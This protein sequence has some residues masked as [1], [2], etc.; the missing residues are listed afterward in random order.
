MTCTD[1][2]TIHQLLVGYVTLFATVTL[3]IKASVL[4]FYLRIF[5]NKFMIR[6]VKVVMIWV[7]LWSVGNIL[8]VFL[9]CRPFA[10]S[11]DPSIKGT[12]GDQKA[13]FIAIG[14]FNVITDVAIL[15]LPIPTIWALKATTRTKIALTAVFAAGFL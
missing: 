11:Y 5:V 1:Q 4:S 7:A 6:A 2:L 12:C 3:T 14:C 10:A 8:Q 13:S 15:C 9:L